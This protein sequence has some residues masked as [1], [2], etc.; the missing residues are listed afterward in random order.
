MSE[1]TTSTQ[2]DSGCLVQGLVFA[3]WLIAAAA[4]GWAIAFTHCAASF[5]GVER[6]QGQIIDYFVVLVQG[7]YVVMSILGGVGLAW[8]TR[9][10]LQRTDCRSTAV[11]VSMGAAAA[12]VAVYSMC[13]ASWLAGYVAWLLEHRY[14]DLEG[15]VLAGIFALLLGAIVWVFALANSGGGDPVGTFYLALLLGTAAYYLAIVLWTA[16]RTVRGQKRLATCRQ[17]GSE[18]T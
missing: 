9:W 7:S 10:A 17:A 6:L 3:G 1:E 18:G 13:H 15:A 11:A 4:M 8:V 14:E 12:A 16:I 2:W 5:I